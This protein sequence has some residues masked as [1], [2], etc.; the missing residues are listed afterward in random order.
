MLQ[1]GVIRPSNSPWA[2][3]VTLVPKS[4]GS[5][6]FCVDYRKLN[7]VTKRDSYPLPRICDIMDTLGRSKIFST[8]DLKSAYHQIPVHPADIEKT[9]FTFH[10][11]LF[12]FTRMPFG[13]ANAPASL[14]RIMDYIFGDMLGNSIMI[15]LDDIVVFSKS[16]EEHVIALKEVFTRLRKYGLRLKASKCCFGQ[17]QV[18]L[19]GFI[20]SE[21]GQAADPV[22]IWTFCGFMSTCTSDTFLF[23]FT[24]FS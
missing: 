3:P 1:Q 4:D 12:E 11:G 19:L 20:I 13:L 23:T 2:S 14:Q 15:Y 21:K 7:S 22:L 24:V 17:K 8:M 10:R 5:P 16:E 18:K 6:R 9:G